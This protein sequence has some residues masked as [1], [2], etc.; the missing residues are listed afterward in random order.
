MKSR[1]VGTRRI[2]P[3]GLP[4]HSGT[5]GNASGHSEALRGPKGAEYHVSYG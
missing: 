4:M 2:N 5:L 3:A 1:R